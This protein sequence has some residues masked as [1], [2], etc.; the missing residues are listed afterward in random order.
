MSQIPQLPPNNPFEPGPLRLNQY[1]PGQSPALMND[2]MG[3]IISMF[4]MPMLQQFAGPGKF[5]PQLTPGQ[6][7][8]DQ[9]MAK[10]A[11]QNA[12][13]ATASVTAANTD[14]VDK[15]ILGLMSMFTR[16]PVDQLNKAD[17]SNFGSMLNHPS[18]KMMLGQQIGPENLEALMFGRKGDP[19]ALAATIGRL[20]FFRRDTLGG[21]RMSAA[22]MADFT[23]SLYHELYG[24]EEK[25]NDMRG[26]MAGQTAQLYENLFQRGI[27][28]QSIGA[29]SA[30]DRV[31]AIAEDS[32]P[33]DPETMKRLAREYATRDLTDSTRMFTVG[34]G[35]DRTPRRFSELTAEQKEDVL[36]QN[37]GKYLQTLNKTLGHVTQFRRDDGRTQSAAEIEKLA[38]YDVLARQVDAGK[39]A[40]TL[41]EYTGAVAAIREIFGD[42]GNPNAPMPQLLAALEHLGRGSITQVGAE[43]VENTLRSMRLAARDAGIGFEQMA[44]MHGQISAYADTLGVAQPT[45]LQVTH[46]AMVVARNLRTSGDYNRPVF[47]RS[48][49]AALAQEAAMMMLHGADSGVSGALQGLVGLVEA[50]PDKYKGNEGMQELVKAYR[51]N[52]ETFTLKSGETFNL[53]DIAGKQKVAGLANLAARFGVTS[54]EFYSAAINPMNQEFQ[55]A[56]Y[57][58]KTMRPEAVQLMA[59]RGG[60]EGLIASRM[61]YDVPEEAL[62]A[63]GLTEDEKAN[64]PTVLGQKIAERM[65]TKEVANL[66]PGERIELLNKE[67]RNDLIAAIGGPDAGTKADT[68]LGPGK[69]FGEGSD[70][71]KAFLFSAVGNVEAILD[72]LTGMSLVNN[73]II[74]DPKTQA[75]LEEQKQADAAKAARMKKMQA[76]HES[77]FLQRFGEYAAQVG[78][79]RAFDFEGL[80]NYVLDVI[81]VADLAKSAAPELVPFLAAAAAKAGEA[82]ADAAAAKDPTQKEALTKKYETYA[83]VF[84]AYVNGKDAE[85]LKTAAEKLAEL[86]NQG[87]LKDQYVA[88]AAGDK[89]ALELLKGRLGEDQYKMVEGL[90]KTQQLAANEKWSLSEILPLLN[91]SADTMQK[92]AQENAQKENEERARKVQDRA[93]NKNK[94]PQQKL[95]ETAQAWGS[96]AYSAAMD[97]AEGFTA[98]SNWM[99][100]GVESAVATMSAG[101][102]QLTADSVTISGGG[103]QQTANVSLKQEE[104]PRGGREGATDIQLVSQQSAGGPKEINFNGEIVLKNLREGI[105]SAIGRPPIHV[106]NGPSVRTT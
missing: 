100:G 97:A 23:Q 54:E 48:E 50:N 1:A 79:G 34:E 85:G 30:A 65:L 9:M 29:L 13:A 60:I 40:D 57:N 91:N 44:G 99:K 39:T 98:V 95:E 71:R 21:E 2:P 26:F 25:T 35:D 102:V 24:T 55:N 7:L 101:T 83:D 41:K 52:R 14:A 78:D 12:L 16:T 27:L 5:L 94:S 4:G 96:A 105:L 87:A 63:A 42:N 72:H 45:A 70:A 56:A 84:A 51:E 104:L 93:K 20:G 22:S 37:E 77:S 43:K 74:L 80:S 17:A 19:A 15:R 18:V 36:K 69:L 31:K 62:N 90:H 66:P 106:Q 33:R 49:P 28:P 59:S 64:L 89:K 32:R 58:F 46:N 6:Q 67:L 8:A 38:G 81:D 103:A 11:Q 82:G 53:A 3:L 92:V 75:A 47:G 76:G 68:L 10:L 73:A 86:D 88:A 61:I